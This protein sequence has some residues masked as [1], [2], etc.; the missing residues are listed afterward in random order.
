MSIKSL[1]T[2]L[3]K[4]FHFQTL[5]RWHNLRG[6]DELNFKPIKKHNKIFYMDANP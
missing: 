4:M 2:I 3:T 5:P 6:V 1:L